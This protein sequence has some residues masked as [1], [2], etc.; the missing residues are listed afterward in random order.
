[1]LCACEEDLKAGAKW[2]RTHA[3]CDQDLRGHI[4]VVG[5]DPQQKVLLSQNLGARVGGRGAGGTDGARE[6]RCHGN[7]T[8][9]DAHLRSEADCCLTPHFTCERPAPQETGARCRAPARQ[10]VNAMASLTLAL[11]RCK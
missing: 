6:L 5:E 11:D 1:M 2:G 9:Y 3:D 10:G 4:K 8:R 7:A